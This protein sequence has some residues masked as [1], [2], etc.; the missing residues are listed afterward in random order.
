MHRID[1]PTRDIDRH[2]PGRDGFTG[3]DPERL[4]PPT[5][6]TDDW[7]NDLQESVAVAIESTGLE[8]NKGSDHLLLHAFRRAAAGQGV[9]N[10]EL[11]PL[12]QQPLLRPGAVAFGRRHWIV[13][14]EDGTIA[15]S[16]NGIDWRP[17]TALAGDPDLH[18]V[19]AF[20]IVTLTGLSLSAYLVGDAG[21]IAHS[22]DDGGTW[23]LIAS[24]HTDA[25][26]A[27]KRSSRGVFVAGDSSRVHR[28]EGTT[29]HDE[30]TAL[31]YAGTFHGIGAHSQHST[32]LL[33]GD[34]GEI[35]RS[36]APGVFTRI[37]AHPAT[38]TPL[39]DA[40][41]LG[42]DRWIAVGGDYSEDPV[43]WASTDDGVTWQAVATSSFEDGAQLHAVHTD[44]PHVVIA[45]HVPDTNG[46]LVPT[47]A[48]WVSRDRGQSFLQLSLL[49][50]NQFRSL[51]FGN[52]RWCVSGLRPSGA[53]DK[54]LM[55]SQ[56][57]WF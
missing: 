16:V 55:F 18:D 39:R 19:D 50:S 5:T 8:L 3:G 51:A 30:T 31:G 15:Q 45:G 9:V 29:R 37:T 10:W 52:H 23:T 35:Q 54:K 4:V 27:V 44:G 57:M 42:D 22:D 25:L 11:P 17:R 12:G 6:V 56:R 26:R 36:T 7:L 33:L 28:I 34:N 53:S 21:T 32:V 40:V 41:Y 47:G 14:G 49:E 1:H 20:W 2:G 13:V 24:G 38:T 46:G 48:V 43:C